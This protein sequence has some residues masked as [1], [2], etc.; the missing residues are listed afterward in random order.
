MRVTIW[1]FWLRKSLKPPSPVTDHNFLSFPTPDLVQRL[2]V[3]NEETAAAAR[4]AITKAT[5]PRVLPARMCPQHPPA[6]ILFSLKFQ[7]PITPLI[8]ALRPFPLG[9]G[10]M[11]MEIPTTDV[12]MQDPQLERLVTSVPALYSDAIWHHPN[13]E[14][15]FPDEDDIPPIFLLFLYI[16]ISHQTGP[17]RT[18]FSYSLADSAVGLLPGQTCFS[19]TSWS[20]AVYRPQDSLNFR[21]PP[22]WCT[23][24]FSDPSTNK[25]Q[26]V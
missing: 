9:R 25:Y 18:E 11:I 24:G 2:A 22:L 19:V 10:P 15:E 13:H 3:Q 5:K 20:F 6:L 12:Q 1:I 23:L 26:T 16:S 4:A 17:V 14:T 7:I 21:T 8:S